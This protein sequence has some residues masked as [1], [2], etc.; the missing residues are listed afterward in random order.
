MYKKLTPKFNKYKLAFKK[1][2]YAFEEINEED[3]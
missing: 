3:K 1:C 2:E